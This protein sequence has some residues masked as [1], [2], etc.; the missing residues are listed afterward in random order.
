MKLNL[1][2]YTDTYEPAVDGVVNSI[3]NF[4]K[5]LE[6]RGH[7][8]YIFTSTKIGSNVKNRKDVFFYKGIGFKPYPQYSMALFPYHSVTTLSK[9]D[10]DIIHSHTPFFMGFSGLVS[11]RLLKTPIVGSFHTL[12]NNKAIVNDYYPKNKQLK[13]LTTKYLWK[14][15]MFFYKKCNATTV[16][17]EAIAELLARHGIRDARVVPNMVDTQM[18]NTRVSED[19]FREERGI[20]GDDKV[21]LYV[22]RLS[23]EKRLDVLLKSAKLL[24]KKDGI[25]FVITGSGP[26]EIYYKSMA[27]R[28][29]LSNVTFT[30][31]VKHEKLPSVYAA[32][33]VFCMPSTFE[34]QGIVALEAMA[35]GKPVVGADFLALRRLIKNGKNGEK[36]RAGNYIDCTRKIERVLND[37]DAYTRGA[38]ETAMMFSPRSVTD[39]IIDVYRSVL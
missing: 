7:K 5:E 36:F 1:A 3:N 38:V 18:F 15:V 26:A 32:S 20:S 39:K 9:F 16:P 37:S 29:R 11:A 2:F 25:K 14:Y 13:K 30:G 19:G 8:V 23:K 22:G 6:K 35:T 21:V 31:F 24:Q 17:S 4:K 33:D 10:I 28:L 34:T 27:K 12:V